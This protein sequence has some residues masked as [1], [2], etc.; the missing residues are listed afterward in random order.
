MIGRGGQG[1]VYEAEQDV[2]RRPVAVKVIG[3]SWVSASSRRRFEEEVEILGRLEHPGIARIYEG[4]VTPGPFGDQPYFVMELVLGKPLTEHADEHGLD[5]AARV[6][7]LTRICE[8]VEHAH[9]KLV[10]HCDLKPAN[11]LVTAERAGDDPHV[12]RPLILDFGIAQVLGRAEVELAAGKGTPGFMA[13]EQE[14]GERPDVRWDVFAL[15][16]IG[17]LLVSGARARRDRHHR[18][19]LDAIL[20]KATERDPGRRYRSVEEFRKDL[21][22]CL[23]FEPPEGVPTSRARRVALFARRHRKAVALLALVLAVASFAAWQG[24][25]AQRAESRAIAERERKASL[26]KFLD[27][28]MKLLA[29]EIARGREFTPKDVLERSEETARRDFSRRSG[30]ARADPP[31]ARGE[32]PRVG[33]ARAGG[34]HARARARGA[35]ARARRGRSGHARSDDLRSGSCGLHQGR[36]GD[37]VELLRETHERCLARFGALDPLTLDDRAHAR[38]QSHVHRRLVRGRPAAH[39][40]PREPRARVRPDAPRPCS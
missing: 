8:A 26:G 39:G 22:R 13:P 16:K 7:L 32:V 17:A 19:E 1:I 12:G 27:E 6:R 11:I 2:P 4:G 21:E 24:F 15:G 10:V 38:L 28:V 25:R 29:P 36:Y 5:L 14:A 37:A 20:G 18:D 35:R 30:G 23:R 40:R 33:F 34:A 3:T 31:E 9:G